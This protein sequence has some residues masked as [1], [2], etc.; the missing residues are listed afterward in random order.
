MTDEEVKKADE[1]QAEVT[2][3]P[4]PQ[5]ETSFIKKNMSYIVMGGIALI[6][7]IAG[8]YFKVVKKRR[9]NASEDDAEEE[10]DNT[11]DTE[12]DYISGDNNK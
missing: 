4:E 11:S 6:A 9:E 2:P 8:Y 7:I 3:T 5:K 10:E 1:E 12:D